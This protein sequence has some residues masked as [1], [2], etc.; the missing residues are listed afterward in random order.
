MMSQPEVPYHQRWANTEL[1]LQTM[2]LVALILS[3]CL[4]GSICVNCYLCSRRQIVVAIDNAGGRTVLRSTS[5]EPERMQFIRNLLATLYNWDA[6]TY[7][8]AYRAAAALMTDDLAMRL[9][10][11]LDPQACTGIEGEGMAC[12]FVIDDVRR[13]AGNKWTATGIKTL[14]GRSVHDRQRVEF[15]IELVT[16]GIKDY[17]PWGLSVCSL[18]EREVR[19]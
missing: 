4:L 8:G 9:L 2:K 12:S 18:R 15:E 1:T 7:Q 5:G 17:N 3:I 14:Q 19:Q 10:A 16:C 13:V 6:R 11:S